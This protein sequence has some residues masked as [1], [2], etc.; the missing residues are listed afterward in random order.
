LLVADEEKATGAMVDNTS[1]TKMERHTHSL[2][3]NTQT[4]KRTQDTHGEKRYRN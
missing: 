4:H 1:V 3:N 2:V